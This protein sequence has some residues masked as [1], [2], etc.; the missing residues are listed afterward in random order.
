MSLSRQFAPSAIIAASLFGIVPSVLYTKDVDLDEVV[1]KYST[2]L[3]SPELFQREP[4]LWKDHFLSTLPELRPASPAEAITK[5]DRTLF[6]N[7]SV[8]LQIACTIPVMSSE[9]KRSASALRGLNNYIRASMGK[10][11]LPN[12]ALLYIHYDTEV[13]LDSVVDCYT[14]LHPRRL[15][16]E[17]LLF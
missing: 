10:V 17:S 1:S 6:P 15:E 12:L 14:R 3:P 7:L 13:I 4:R 5:C 8:L 2:D 11:R 9:C 16:L